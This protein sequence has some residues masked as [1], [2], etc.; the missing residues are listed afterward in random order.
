MRFVCGFVVFGGD[1]MYLL[2]GPFVHGCQWY[3][4]GDE[5]TVF[6]W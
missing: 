1:L 6:V 3:C 2:L 4:F 5:C